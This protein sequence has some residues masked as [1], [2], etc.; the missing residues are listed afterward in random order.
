MKTKG[1]PARTMMCL[2]GRLAQTVFIRKALADEVTL[3]SLK[4]R[5]TPKF[6]IGI[7]LVGISYI[8]G[9]PAVAFFTFLAVYLNMKLIALL[10]PV[11]YIFSHL[12]FLA[13]AVLAGVNGI[14]YARTFK[15]WAMHRLAL[16]LMKKASPNIDKSANN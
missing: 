13:G 8:I 11:S 2:T 3:D 15:R 9:W 4:Q 6:I 10:G 7:S 5:P 12:V 14:I 1:I 16:W